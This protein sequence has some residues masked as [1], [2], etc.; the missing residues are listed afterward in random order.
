MI[1]D[2][3]LALCKQCKLQSWEFTKGTICSLTNDYPTFHNACETFE[4]DAEK[5]EKYKRTVETRKQ[6]ELED[7]TFGLNSFGIKSQTI[8][9]LIVAFI[10]VLLTSFTVIFMGMI[11]LWTIG[12]IATGIVFVARGTKEIPSLIGGIMV[13]VFGVA[14]TV[15]TI[16]FLGLITIWSLALVLI[17]IIFIIMGIR[18]NSVRDKDDTLDAQL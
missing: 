4:L 11:S 15:I 14:L 1:T 17:G 3:Q 18:G 13:L 6:N 12:V 7:K 5:A 16:F 2:E 9:G 8:A 10:G